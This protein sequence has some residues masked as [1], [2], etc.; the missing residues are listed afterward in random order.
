MEIMGKYMEIIDEAPT[1]LEVAVSV[2]NTSR[3]R[4][5]PGTFQNKG[6]TLRGVSNYF[7]WLF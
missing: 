2:S 1:C 4:D 6:D 5:T 7:N 3:T